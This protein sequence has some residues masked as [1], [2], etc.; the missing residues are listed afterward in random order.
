MIRNIFIRLFNF[1]V[2]NKV[3]S[4]LIPCTIFFGIKER[5]KLGLDKRIH[6]LSSKRITILALDS[7]RYRGDL[8]ILAKNPNF[9]V[10]FISQK[11]Q[12]WFVKPFYKDITSDKIFTY[13]FSDKDSKK[14]K[15]YMKAQNFMNVFLKKL[16][17]ALSINCVL[18]VNYRY[19]EDHHWTKSAEI[20][21]IPW[22]M[23]YREGL[24]TF[25]S[26]YEGVVFRHKR[27]GKFHG[28]HIIVHNSTIMQT[29][30][31]AKICDESQI[32][33]AGALRMDSLLEAIKIQE[34]KVDTSRRKRIVFF[35][36]PINNGVFGMDRGKPRDKNGAYKFSVWKGRDNF[37]REV[38]ETLLE[39][40]SENPDIDIVIKPKDVSFKADSWNQYLNIV[41]NS[42]IDAEKLD[43]YSIEP[44][45]DVHSLI[46]NSDVICGLQSSTMLESLVAQKPTII[47]LFEDFRETELCQKEFG[48]YNYLNL[49]EVAN[50]KKHFKHIIINSLQNYEIKKDVKKKRKELFYEWFTQPESGSLNIYSSIIGDIVNKKSN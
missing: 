50:N 25:R 29:F 15:I 12:G 26:V 42:P 13:Y 48:L 17:S 43:N 19:F 18:T 49:F 38:H 39:I 40:A 27:Y 46:L 6:K 44:Y 24:L 21:N 2:L 37:F 33:V 34:G 7:N 30:L 5:T 4:I 22:I 47:P 28:S 20:L 10:L 11:V 23:L 45:A 32:T 41:N 1:L 35:Y 36:F 9:R 31:D 14:Y 16:Y 8:D 3:Y